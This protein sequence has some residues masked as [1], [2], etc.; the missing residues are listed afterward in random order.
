MEYDVILRMPP[1]QSAPGW[2][3]L[4]RH[5]RCLRVVVE[6]ARRLIAQAD[7]RVP[8]ESDFDA[9]EMALEALDE[10]ERA[11]CVIGDAPKESG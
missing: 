7:Y 8:M 1:R 4:E 10:E 3:V 5:F 9:L 11:T 2:L 6:A